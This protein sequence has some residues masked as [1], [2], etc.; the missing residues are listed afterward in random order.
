MVGAKVWEVFMGGDEPTLEEGAGRS[1]EK[2]N[3]RWEG[4]AR[5]TNGKYQIQIEI[6][7]PN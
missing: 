5:I 7:I 1:Q 4:S 6:E 2:L 3:Q